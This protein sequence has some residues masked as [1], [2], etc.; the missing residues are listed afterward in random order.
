MLTS[1][2]TGPI[3]SSSV[4]SS[5]PM[6]VRSNGIPGDYRAQQLL[7]TGTV[8]SSTRTVETPLKEVE[9]VGIGLRNEIGEYNCFLNVVIQVSFSISNLM[10]TMDLFYFKSTALKALDY[11]I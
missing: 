6:T 11:C 9:E 3:A 8:G 5:P 1:Q 7:E 10:S 2:S 4:S